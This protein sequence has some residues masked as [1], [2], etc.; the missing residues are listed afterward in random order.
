MEDGPMVLSFVTFFECCLVYVCVCVR[1][2]HTL[3]RVFHKVCRKCKLPFNLFPLS[4][5][6]IRSHMHTFMCVVMSLTGIY[7]Q[8]LCNAAGS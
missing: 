7:Q 6:S 8:E 2:S 3:T 4:L 5:L 1:D